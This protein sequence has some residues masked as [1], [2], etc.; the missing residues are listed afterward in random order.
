MP[1]SRQICS[2]F[3][4]IACLEFKLANYDIT[5]LHVSQGAKQTPLRTQNT[6]T[7]NAKKKENKI[8]RTIRFLV[9]IIHWINLYNFCL[10]FFSLS[11]LINSDELKTFSLQRKSDFLGFPLQHSFMVLN[12]AFLALSILSNKYSNQKNIV[13]GSWMKFVGLGFKKK[14]REKIFED[15]CEDFQV[16]LGFCFL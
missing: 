6:K 2:K 3:N 10:F 7:E 1:I 15:H 5:V 12:I 13:H 9:W 4:V 14:P 11:Q 8:V 16:I